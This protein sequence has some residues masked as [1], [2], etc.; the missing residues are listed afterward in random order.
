MLTPANSTE[1]WQVLMELRC[2][3]EVIERWLASG[4][5]ADDLQRSLQSMLGEVQDQVRLL[6]NGRC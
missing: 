5:L 4:L 6:T 2:R 1:T 3:Q